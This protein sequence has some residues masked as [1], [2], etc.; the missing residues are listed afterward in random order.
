MLNH[1]A[2]IGLA[3]HY[4]QDGGRTC[5][6]GTTN[7]TDDSHHNVRYASN[8]VAAKLGCHSSAKQRCH[9][10]PFFGVLLTEQTY[11]IERAAKSS[12]RSFTLPN[13]VNDGWRS[14]L[15]KL[16]ASWHLR[17]MSALPQDGHWQCVANW[18]LKTNA[19]FAHDYP[20]CLFG[21]YEHPLGYPHIL[22][23]QIQSVFAAAQSN[24]ERAKCVSI[25]AFNECSHVDMRP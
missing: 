5:G 3:V 9:L 4:I 25:V 14:A 22:G 20:L 12:H 15:G 6:Q 1:E 24:R 11:R 2:L 10:P 19:V 21:V 23:H 7:A 13:F 18:M 17:E 8:C 16:I